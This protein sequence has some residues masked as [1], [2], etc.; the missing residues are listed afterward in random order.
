VRGRGHPMVPPR[1]RAGAYIRHFSIEAI[2]C[3]IVLASGTCMVHSAM[4]DERMLS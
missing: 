4:C 1:R 2:G 3:V